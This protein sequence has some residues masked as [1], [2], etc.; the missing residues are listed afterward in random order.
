MKDSK[1]NKNKEPFTDEEIKADEN[2]D[3]LMKQHATS[4]FKKDLGVIG[5]VVG[6]VLLVTSLV[7]Y[8]S[9]MKL[10]MKNMEVTATES[11]GAIRPNLFDIPVMHHAVNAEKGGEII[12]NSSK[13]SIPNNA[14]VDK[15][16]EIVVGE[17]E[18]TYREFHNPVD[19][20]LSGIPMM[21]DSAGYEYHF[22]SA[23][24]FE[25]Y[26]YQ[27]GVPVK[28]TKPVSVSLSSL[29]R[30][31][32]FNI[33]Q[34]D[35][36]SGKWSFISKDSSKVGENLTPYIRNSIAKIESQISE[37]AK[38]EP[39]KKSK[40]GINIKIDFNVEEFPELASFKKVLFEIDEQD[41]NFSP[42][43]AKKDWDDV[44]LK[45][46]EDDYI[47][48]FYDGFKPTKIKVK[49]V[50]SNRQYKK[51]LK[52]YNKKYADRLSAFRSRK[53]SL[54]KELA[55][56]S[57]VFPSFGN[58]TRG[59]V[60]RLFE[61][62]DFG[63]WNSDCPMRMPKGRVLASMYINKI[64]GTDKIDT[65]DFK[66]IYLV[67]ENKNTLYRITNNGILSFNPAKKYVLW[68]VDEKEQL[69]V[70]S[71]VKFN[72]IPS[73][74]DSTYAFEMEISKIK[75]TNVDDVRKELNLQKLFKDV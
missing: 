75:P 59:Y 45:K 43:L 46:V 49:P 7:V 12:F 48:T 10:V 57:V 65:L 37:I 9:D 26:G 68:A 33:Y 39:Q 17:V 28:L 73:Q 5:L 41:K 55:F 22:E 40:K 30:G 21:Y 1:I 66:T 15:D 29:H 23:G 13:I 32:Y 52:E 27:N 71:A 19:F 69:C 58:S 44:K 34:L 50:L 70:F 60:E 25:I 6:G 3:K 2:F 53:D 31:G 14:F 11:E 74:L 64:K 54:E 16:G 35:T 51:A 62:N 63:V 72:S 47:L 56:Y 18:I 61:I 38:D 24:M 36:L 67:E 42:D 8:F 4:K 20:F